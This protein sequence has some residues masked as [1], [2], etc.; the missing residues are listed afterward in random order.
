[1]SWWPSKDHDRSYPNKAAA[2]KGIKAVQTAATN[3]KIDDLT[4]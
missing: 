3:A 4:P 2:K 1:L